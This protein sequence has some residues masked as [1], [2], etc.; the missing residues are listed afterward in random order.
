VEEEDGTF[1]C[2]CG[3]F[4][5]LIGSDITS[6]NRCYHVRYMATRQNVEYAFSLPKVVI[7]IKGT[8]PPVAYWV[9]GAFVK[10]SGVHKWTCSSAMHKSNCS[11]T[12]AVQHH[13]DT[14]SNATGAEVAEVI[15]APSVLNVILHAYQ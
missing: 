14:M 4:A 10:P 3:T 13:L 7:P 6:N 11:H 9:D 15:A 1:S 5:L 2:S 8:V 12:R